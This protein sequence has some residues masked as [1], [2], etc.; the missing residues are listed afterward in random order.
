MSSEAPLLK[1]N[2][3]L[4]RVKQE[5]ETCPECGEAFDSVAA[6]SHQATDDATSR[7]FYFQFLHPAGKECISFTMAVDFEAWMTK[8]TA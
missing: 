4:A 5:V 1:K 6:N 3:A 8:A 7:R 2:E